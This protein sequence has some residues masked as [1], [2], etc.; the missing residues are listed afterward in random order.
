[1]TLADVPAGAALFLDANILVYHFAPEPA[2]GP[3]CD[4]LIRRIE[5]GELSGLTSTHVLSETAHRLMATEAIA[6]FGWPYAGIA[7]R[8]KGH[9]AEVQKLTAFRRALQTVVASKINVLSITPALV[10]AAA[11]V[12]QQ[13]G[14]LSNDALIVAVMQGHGLTNLASN[15]ADFDRVPGLTRYAPA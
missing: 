5:M 1:M 15:D 14:L 8:L 9:A 12:S 13:T 3:D 7:R 6:L 10:L 4:S 11:T 2:F